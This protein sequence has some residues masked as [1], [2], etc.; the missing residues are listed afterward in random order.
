MDKAKTAKPAIR[1]EETFLVE[2]ATVGMPCSAAVV[3]Y[4][5]RYDVIDDIYII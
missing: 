1:Q 2:P 4:N 5:L 3:I